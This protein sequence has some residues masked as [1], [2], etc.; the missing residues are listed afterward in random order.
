[1]E[2]TRIGIIGVGQIGK[3]HVRRYSEMESVEIVAIADIN[4]TEANRVSEL[5]GIPNVYTD[6]RELLQRDDILAVDVCLHNN[7]HMPMTVAALEAGKHVYCEKPMAGAYIDAETMYRT[8]QE[9]G[10]MLSIQL[11]TLYA[12]ETKAAKA[13]IDDGM[14]GK[15]YHARSTGFR[16]RGRPFVDGYG[17]MSFVQKQI[18]AGGALYDMGVYHIARM[19]YLLGNPEV[20]RIS[21]KIYQETDVDAA[22]KEASGYNVEELGLGLVRLQDGIMLDIIEAWAI[23]L[24]NIEGS[25]IV[26]SQGGVRLEPF[27]YFRSIGHLDMDGTANLERFMYRV[28]NVQGVGDEY[29]SAQ[30]HWIAALQGR[31]ELLPTAELALKTMLISEGIY[32]SDRLGR[33]VSAQE[34]HEHS[35]STAVK[36]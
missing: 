27:G 10:Q 19:L 14:L 7:F 4:E 18:S 3:A 17:S 22:R 12:K 6:F 31:V 11:N 23:H 20:Q 1:M 35:V 21:G 5:Y 24:D 25:T 34:V 13:L 8:A 9:T 2:K 16:R 15:V 26:G 36:V 30:H 32:L 28:Y 29:D 33:E